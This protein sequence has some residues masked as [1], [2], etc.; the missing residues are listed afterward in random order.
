MNQPAPNTRE[1]HRHQASRCAA[2]AALSTD[3]A[4]TACYAVQSAYHAA[5]ALMATPAQPAQ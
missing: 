5:E 2:R 3:K 4:R 1:Y